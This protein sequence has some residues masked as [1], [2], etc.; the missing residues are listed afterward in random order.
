MDSVQVGQV[1]EQI[2]TG[3]VNRLIEVA[4]IEVPA[5]IKEATST[6]TSV[7]LKGQ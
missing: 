5:S 4:N 6:S 3:L 7:T 2:T 1:P